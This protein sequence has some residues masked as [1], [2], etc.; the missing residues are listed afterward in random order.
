MGVCVE[1]GFVAAVR[2][3]EERGYL[4]GRCQRHTNQKSVG[5]CQVLVAMLT[6]PAHTRPVVNQTT[7]R[8]PMT[9]KTVLTGT[10]PAQPRPRQ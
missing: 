4:G 2:G 10:A 8:A 7:P 3:E 6:R 5:G 1:E 9:S